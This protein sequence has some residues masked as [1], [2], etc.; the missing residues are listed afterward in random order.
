[1]KYDKYKLTYSFDIENLGIALAMIFEEVAE[2]EDRDTIEPIEIWEA[3][4]ERFEDCENM[5]FDF[6]ESLL[7]DKGIKVEV[8]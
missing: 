7:E 1:M 4:H 2:Y 3:I 5:I 6:V 8:I